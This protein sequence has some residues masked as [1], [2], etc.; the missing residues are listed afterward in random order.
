MKTVGIICE[1]DPFHNGHKYMIDRLREKGADRVICLMS[2]DVTQRGEFAILP[3]KYRAEAAVLGG[4]D[5]VFE[6]PYP[7]CSASAGYF[8][9][10]GVY[11]LAALGVDT[12]AFG[13]ECG[14]IDY[15][16][17][18]AEKL[19]NKISGGNCRSSTG[20]AKEYLSLVGLDGAGANDVLGV[21]YIRSA[22]RLGLDLKFETI[23]RIGAGHG[24][25]SDSEYGGDKPC[26]IEC[27]DAVRFDDE[28]SAGESPADEHFVEECSAEECCDHVEDKEKKVYPSA[29]DL[30]ER[31]IRTVTAGWIQ[32]EIQKEPLRG[33]P[34]EASEGI[35]KEAT[36]EIMR[37]IPKEMPTEM[38]ERIALAILSGDCPVTTDAVETAVLAYWRITLP[39]ESGRFAEC[40]GGVAERLHKAAKTSGT[41][42]E[43][44]AAAATK[45]YTNARLKRAAIFAMTGVKSEDL[46]GL[47]AYVTLLAANGE[48]RAF[49]AERRRTRT[50]PVV[51]KPSRV[52]KVR[53]AERQ[54]ELSRRMDALTTLARPVPCGGGQI[55]RQSPAVTSSNSGG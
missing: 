26:A 34:K 21:E 13:S 15:L 51:T 10:A 50:V 38:R 35:P 1:Y 55:L 14:D 9:S 29:T 5:A 17:E 18:T 19:P 39:E 33:I 11:L 49:L 23:K 53:G 24:E 4:A 12:V 25:L 46:H 54:N 32:E 37:E 3:K 8:S 22:R 42:R 27:S 6:L 48:G 52:P 36:E 43:M 44:I 45:K 30:R 20:T 7:W 31:I 41:Y 40:G 16:M 28:S 47:P 2:G